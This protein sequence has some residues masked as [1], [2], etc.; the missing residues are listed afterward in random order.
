MRIVPVIA[1]AVSLGA[2]AAIAPPGSSRSAPLSAPYD[3][4]AGSAWGGGAPSRVSSAASE[5]SAG[6]WKLVRKRLSARTSVNRRRGSAGRGRFMATGPRAEPTLRR[7]EGASTRNNLPPNL[8]WGIGT[9][10]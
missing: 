6:R 5:V 9:G 10:L 7:S 1:L 3:G 4:T 2:T 8:G